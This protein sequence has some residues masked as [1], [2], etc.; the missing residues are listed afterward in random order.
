M[1]D[2]KHVIKNPSVSIDGTD[3]SG[4]FRSVTI[5]ESKPRVDATGFGNAMME[6]RPGIGDG[7]MEFEAYNDYAAGSL[8]PLLQAIYDNDAQVI[9]I[10]KPFPGAVAA[11][12]PAYTMTGQ[13]YGWQPLSGT[14]NEMNTNRVTFYNA[15]DTGIVADTTP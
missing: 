11:N 1:P 6:S 9:I 8:T 14:I 4:L 15:S 12:N 2:G 13:L 3:L 7:S 10:V 5:D